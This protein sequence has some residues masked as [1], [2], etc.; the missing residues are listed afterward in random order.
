[1]PRCAE[2]WCCGTGKT[3]KNDR[4]QRVLEN[5]DIYMCK[6]LWKILQSDLYLIC[7][8]R[9]R[10]HVNAHSGVVA[11]VAMSEWTVATRALRGC[12]R[13]E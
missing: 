1:M 8:M 7:A 4:A 6:C 3:Q 12:A 9:L 10:A 13:G 2:P 11:E 5:K